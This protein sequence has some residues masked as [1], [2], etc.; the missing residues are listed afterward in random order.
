MI[1]LYAQE[2]EQVH[3]TLLDT[4]GDDNVNITY[5]I[6]DIQNL[7]QKEA[8]YSKDFLLPATDTN[9]QF[10]DHYHD[11][12]RYNTYFNPYKRLRAYIEVDG[13]VVIEGFMNLLEVNKK[14]EMHNY[15]VVV[16]DE[17]ATLFDIIKGARFC[18]LNFDD[19]AHQRYVGNWN[20]DNNEYEDGAM[21]DN[22]LNSFNGGIYKD[23][24]TSISAG[25]VMGEQTDNVLYPL[26]GNSHMH[27]PVGNFYDR[28][29]HKMGT[30]SPL[31]LKLKY[32]IDKI[33]TYAGFVYESTFFNS[34][35]FTGIYFDTIIKKHE[36]IYDSSFYFNWNCTSHPQ[37]IS[38]GA[39]AV[40]SGLSITEFLTYGD[41]F[42]DQNVVTT[43]TQY[44]VAP[45]SGRFKGSITADFA[46][47][48]NYPVTVYMQTTVLGSE[49]NNGVNV[50]DEVIV[51]A[52]ATTFSMS[53]YGSTYVSE[54]AVG[55]IT[56]SASDTGV[57]FVENS[58]QSPSV[59]HGSYG[60][61]TETTTNESICARME[62][63][64]I[65]AILRDVF[66]MFNL[67]AEPVGESNTLR[68]EPFS[69]F[70]AKGS[71]LDWTKKVDIEQSKI[72]QI[73]V[74]KRIEF[75][76]AE[77]EDDYYLN[78]YKTNTNQVYG[79]QII[80]FDTD[81]G[82]T[83]KY[84]LEVFAPAL[85]MAQ[86]DDSVIGDIL[87]IGSNGDTDVGTVDDTPR[88]ITEFENKPRIFY[89]HNGLLTL[90]SNMFF[91]MNY[92]GYGVLYNQT[93]YGT[94]HIYSDRT[95]NIDEFTLALSF[96][97]VNPSL[98]SI[99]NVVTKTLYDQY[100]SSYIRERYNDNEGLL[101]TVQIKLNAL[102]IKNFTF[103]NVIKIKHQHYRVN[104]IMYNTNKTKLAKV[105]LYRI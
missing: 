85:V 9:A 88:T 17:T 103:Q 58:S 73:K 18:E 94:A 48:N 97:V 13:I 53:M 37:S 50:I 92:L 89:K 84:E 102:D 46:N 43:A 98:Q 39:G 22:M 3:Y 72:K 38:T 67:V 79:E 42:Y 77:D 1:K 44:M 30:N 95:E 40:I 28:F 99:D 20:T 55:S 41:I 100:Y 76:M 52:N 49:Y 7:G 59:V 5:S 16:Y 2:Q 32:V 27:T 70:M 4:Y 69:Q 104:K 61:E 25:F 47:T 87:H 105:E 10:F 82:Q 66:K 45:T 60:F 64:E 11:V 36:Y 21:H 31:S 35:E 33:F 71:V 51:P 90:D 8:G 24:L 101:Y 91:R 14:G 23:N 54:G 26:V 78:L 12:N 81:E 83:I 19:V 29:T 80:E 6:D 15:K 65:D 68:I 75:R 34:P 96:G 62:D 93:K 74:P 86:E 63:I 56:F 57:T